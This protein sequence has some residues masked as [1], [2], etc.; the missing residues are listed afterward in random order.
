MF[1]P[2]E[3]DGHDLFA[4]FDGRLLWLTELDRFLRVQRLPTWDPVPLAALGAQL[5]PEPKRVRALSQRT[6]REGDRPVAIRS[7]GAVVGRRGRS[8]GGAAQKPRGVRT[9]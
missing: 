2:L 4:L 3:R 7:D 6:G 8:R 9:R 5:A 1:G